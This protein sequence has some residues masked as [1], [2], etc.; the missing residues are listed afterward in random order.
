MDGPRRVPDGLLQ[1]FSSAS[2]V[3]RNTDLL[4]LVVSFSPTWVPANTLK[5]SLM[6]FIALDS[7]EEYLVCSPD[8]RSYLYKRLYFHLIFSPKTKGHSNCHCQR[9]NDGE[10][11]EDSQHSVSL[12]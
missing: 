6:Q 3:Q 10:T 5:F 2:Y 9:I 4:T 8:W 1:L 7:T 11:S 12:S